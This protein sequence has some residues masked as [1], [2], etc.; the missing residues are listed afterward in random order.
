MHLIVWPYSK[1]S[2][3]KIRINYL[4]GQEMK[5]KKA[6]TNAAALVVKEIFHL[7]EQEPNRFSYHWILSEKRESQKFKFELFLVIKCT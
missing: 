4:C 1:D 6:I 7:H 2:H 3:N 5:Q